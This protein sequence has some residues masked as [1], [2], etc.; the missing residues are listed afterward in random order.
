MPYLF[1]PA[2]LFNFDILLSNLNELLCISELIQMASKPFVSESG[3][4]IAWSRSG[5][6]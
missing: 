2:T 6:T 3:L 4:C 5:P 1:F